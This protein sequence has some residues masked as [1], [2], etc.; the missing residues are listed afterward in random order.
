[1]D[2]FV[3]LVWPGKAE[4]HAHKHSL[5]EP[6]QTKE[7]V[8]KKCSTMPLTPR[9]IPFKENRVPGVYSVRPRT[10]TFN[11]PQSTRMLAR[12]EFHN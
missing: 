12:A 6:L 5:A 9:M 4:S 3:Q 7:V 10:I 2:S 1:M 8:P 11:P